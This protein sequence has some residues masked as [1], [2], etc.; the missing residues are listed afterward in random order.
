MKKRV[1][2]K[3][4]EGLKIRKKP[5]FEPFISKESV[6]ILSREVFGNRA[7]DMHEVC[8]LYFFLKLSFLT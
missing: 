7:L 1:C 3:E 6:D 2:K 5:R 4:Q 8:S